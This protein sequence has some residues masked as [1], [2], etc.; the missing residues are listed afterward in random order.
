MSANI[1]PY[2]VQ[3]IYIALAWIL[4]AL[5]FSL[6][7]LSSDTLPT[8]HKMVCDMAT[9]HINEMTCKI[10]KL[11]SSTLIFSAQVCNLF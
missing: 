7:P 6:L 1:T 3:I 4:Y 10:S 9:H 5:H 11:T 2:T 8:K